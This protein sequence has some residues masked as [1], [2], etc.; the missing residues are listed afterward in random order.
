MDGKWDKWYWAPI[1]LVAAVALWIWLHPLKALAIAAAIGIGTLWTL[2]YLDAAQACADS[3]GRL[4]TAEL[5]VKATCQIPGGK[6]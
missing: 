2:D 3:G 4:V 5:S 1:M 6:P